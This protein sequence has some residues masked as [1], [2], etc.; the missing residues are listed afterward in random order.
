[1][2]E[3]GLKHR[4]QETETSTEGDGWGPEGRAEKEQ[5]QHGEGSVTQP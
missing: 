2:R 1:M 3:G 5:R 4:V